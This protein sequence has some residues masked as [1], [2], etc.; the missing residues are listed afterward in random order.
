M[1]KTTYTKDLPNKKI[2]VTREFSA[3]IDQVWE[4][5]TNSELLEQ[6]WAP[7]PYQAKTKTMNFKE[8]GQW[9]YYMLGP[10]GSKSWCKADYKS[11]VPQKSYEGFDSFCDE[12]GN[13]NTEFPSMYWKVVFNSIP[14]GTKVDVEVTFDSQADLE[15]IVELGFEK[16]FAAAHG[17]LDEL[18]LTEIKS[19]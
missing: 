8:G 4:A 5:W 10:D 18:L 6:W 15:K 11:I 12:V 2:F 16:G 1:K 3:S 17:N 9:L 14:N 19:N 13:T 7:K